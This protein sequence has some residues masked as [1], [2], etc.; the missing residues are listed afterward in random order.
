[1]G[2]GKGEKRERRDREEGGSESRAERGERRGESGEGRAE[3]GEG[4]GERGEDKR[5]Q[6]P[7]CVPVFS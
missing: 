6:W 3:R 5:R 7:Q 4:R 1:M 2:E